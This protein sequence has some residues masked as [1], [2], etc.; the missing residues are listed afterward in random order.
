MRA[1]IKLAG[2]GSVESA[3]AGIADPGQREK[4]SIRTGIA[5]PGLGKNV[6]SRPRSSIAATA[7]PPAQQSPRFRAPGARAAYER[8]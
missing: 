4:R 6:E 3:V 5:D 2:R 7:L 1:T 8:K